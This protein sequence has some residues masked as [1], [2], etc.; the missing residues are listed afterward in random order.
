MKKVHNVN[1][2]DIWAKTTSVDIDVYLVDDLKIL[3]NERIKVYN[4]Y[5]VEKFNTKGVLLWIINDFLVYN[6]LLGYA[7]CRYKACLI[8]SDDKYAKYLQNREKV[9]YTKH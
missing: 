1:V 6:N 7:T 9:C 8:C 3:C 4:A 5:R 2:I